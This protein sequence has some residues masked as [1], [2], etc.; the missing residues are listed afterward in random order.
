[1]DFN[2]TKA[3]KDGRLQLCVSEFSLNTLDDLFANVGT[4]K[5]TA[6]KVLQRLISILNPKQE[7]PVEEQAAQPKPAD[8]GKKSAEGITIK[9]IEDTLI[10][11]AQCCKPVPG[12]QVV[13][14]ISRGRG[15]IVHTANCPHVQTLE[16][17][18]LISVN[19]NN[20][21]S[22]PFPAEICVTSRN[23]KGML[24]KIS[25]ALVQQDVNITTLS[26]TSTIDGRS[27]MTFVVDVRDAA[28]LYKT[29]DKLRA[30]ENIIEVRR[31]T[32]NL[33]I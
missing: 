14:F 30:I 9:G 33:E 16:S 29:I 25:T 1:M 8:T 7:T 17:E 32:S 20:E 19:W 31:G 11:F 24:A 22:K 15:V 26:L 3:A 21:E 4:G 2:A 18:R 27:Q 28:H 6:K 23:E 13:G 5:L 12:D 10:H